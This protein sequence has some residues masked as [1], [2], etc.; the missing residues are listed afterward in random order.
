MLD[1]FNDCVYNMLI[2]SISNPPINFSVACLLLRNTVG[3][4]FL[5]QDRNYELLPHHWDKHSLNRA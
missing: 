5:R 1:R 4:H 2:K 3:Q